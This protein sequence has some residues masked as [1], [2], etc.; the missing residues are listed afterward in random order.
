[1]RSQCIG[2]FLVVLTT[3]WCVFARC[4]HGIGI[5]QEGAALLPTSLFSDS[6]SHTHQHG[7]TVSVRMVW[8]WPIAKITSKVSG[9]HVNYALSTTE[10]HDAHDRRR[11]LLRGS[12]TSGM[13]TYSSATKATSHVRSTTRRKLP[14][15]AERLG[16]PGTGGI[17]LLVVIFLI[18]LC[19]CRG[20]LCDILACVCLYEIC[21]DDAGAG[22][23]ELM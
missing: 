17:I 7:G 6:N 3:V 16:A 23:F 15:Y 22:G 8:F 5:Q 21:C 4:G 18:L 1:M 20:M 14:G 10:V 12:N 11:K 13:E 2:L 9:L 19:C